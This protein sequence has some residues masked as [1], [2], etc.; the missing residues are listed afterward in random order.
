[1]DRVCGDDIG[2][3]WCVVAGCLVMRR[4]ALRGH[5]FMDMREAIH[6]LQPRESTHS[7]KVM[8]RRIGCGLVIWE[9]RELHCHPSMTLLGG[10]YKLHCSAALSL[11][12]SSAKGLDERTSPS[13]TY[14]NFLSHG[15]IKSLSNTLNPASTRAP[16]TINLQSHS[17][18][19]LPCR[20]RPQAILTSEE[21]HSSL[22]PSTLEPCLI[23]IIPRRMIIR[24]V[25]NKYL[26]NLSVLVRFL[27]LVL[28]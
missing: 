14:S 15:I 2:Q 18:L 11:L 26:G 10:R 28:L 25:T 5:R 22:A 4:W 24:A 21:P 6:V 12:K 27:R 9:G 3:G 16:T 7:L 23:H 8:P 20:R 13:G 1:M 19:Q 17:L